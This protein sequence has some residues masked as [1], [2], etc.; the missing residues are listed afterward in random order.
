MGLW[1]TFLFGTRA[2]SIMEFPWAQILATSL[3]W[4]LPCNDKLWSLLISRTTALP[5]ASWFVRG[6]ISGSRSKSTRFCSFSGERELIPSCWIEFL[7]SLHCGQ[8]V[9][10]NLPK[11]LGGLTDAACW[12]IHCELI[13][14]ANAKCIFVR[15]FHD[16]ESSDCF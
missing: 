8:L 9:A 2:I 11:K 12:S 6:V 14:S 15:M 13:R 1:A 4:S 10:E 7:T 5:C 3:K 16:H